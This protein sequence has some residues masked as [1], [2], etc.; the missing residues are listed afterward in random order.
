MQDSE[1]TNF[2]P[3]PQYDYSA[4]TQSDAYWCFA[5]TFNETKEKKVKEVNL[6][7]NFQAIEVSKK[8][9]D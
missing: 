7:L 1:D 2:L 8:Q 3:V 4:S 6:V 5:W 9:Q